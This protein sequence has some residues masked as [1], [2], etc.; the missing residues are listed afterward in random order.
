[1]NSKQLKKLRKRIRPIQVEWLRTL[2]PEDQANTITPENV[3]GLL[4]EE[5]HVF[6]QGQL[7]L[8]Y[9]TDKWIMKHLK[10]FPHIKT[11]KELQEVSSNG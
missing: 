2:L 11:Y 4:P 8:S 7:H 9:M 6:G 5:T 3:E 1:M 10:K